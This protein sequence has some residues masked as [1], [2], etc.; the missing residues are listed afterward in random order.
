MGGAVS[1]GP[2]SLSDGD[3]AEL[4]EQGDYKITAEEKSEIVLFDLVLV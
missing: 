4:T 2:E 3:A 1:V